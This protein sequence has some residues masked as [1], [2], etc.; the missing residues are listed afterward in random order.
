VRKSRKQIIRRQTILKHRSKAIITLQKDAADPKT[1]EQLNAHC[2]AYDEAINNNDAAAIAML[3]AED[4]IFVTDRGP[5]CGRQAIE[6]WY[7]DVFKAWRP[8]NHTGKADQDSP[9]LIGTA[10]NE[11]WRT[12]EWSETGQGQNGEP[13]QIKGYWSTIDSLEGDEWKMRMLTWNITPAAT[14][15]ETK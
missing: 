2:H 9:H 5:V 14:T 6:E 11:A 1:T 3:F 8:K 7:A 4:A 12:G 10:G 13:V 15:A